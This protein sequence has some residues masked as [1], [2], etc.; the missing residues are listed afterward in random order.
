MRAEETK[1]KL[2]VKRTILIGLAFLS[3]SAF[4]QFYNNEIPRILK[5]TFGMK[6]TAAGVVMALD[7]VL[8]LFLLPFFGSLSD[9]TETRIGRRMPYIL[10]GTFSAVVLLLI[11][12]RFT[13]DPAAEV[14]FMITLILLLLAMASYRSPAV[15]LMPE[16]TPAPL[17]SKANAIINLMGA[18]G[19]V[20][21]LLLIRL[22]V[23][24]PAEGGLT[25]YLPVIG[26]LAGLMTVCVVVLFFTV[27]EK[28]L[29]DAM[30]AAEKTEKKRSIGRLPDDVRRSM[31][32]LL[33]AE[34]C[35]FAAY[36]AVTTAFSRYVVEVWGL[37][38]SAYT[39][40]LLVATA[41]AVLSYVPIGQLS[42][43]FGRRKMIL[44]GLLL[45]TVCYF[46]G[47]FVRAYTMPV[48]IL[49][50][51]IGFGWAAVGVNSYPMVVEM[52][53]AG[54]IGRF[55]GLYYTS[56]MAAQVF[57]P[58]ASGALLEFIS[59]RTLFPYAVAFS[60]VSLFLMSRVRHGEAHVEIG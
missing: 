56:S 1:M 31:I 8:A 19:G 14:P 3:I 49:F 2:N 33:A 45:M 35:W 6:E 36:N 27:P 55:T 54:E 11:L 21:A 16:L 22:L 4:W 60:L 52:A 24:T 20:A 26:A 53:Q 32:C 41:A 23:K 37:K 40:C 34:F 47:I 7:N 57:T 48:N 38:S 10:L 15:A 50:G 42:Q 25:D 46:L 9:R 13:A 12:A 43:K 58:I 59:Y 28:R 44:L 51:L 29:L 17:R 39:S 18:L 30:P 5:Y